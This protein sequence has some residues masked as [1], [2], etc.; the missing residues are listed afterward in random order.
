MVI[1]ILAIFSKNFQNLEMH[2]RLGSLVIIFWFSPKND[3][4]GS[5]MKVLK[6]FGIQ[7]NYNASP[8]KDPDIQTPLVV[9]FSLEVVFHFRH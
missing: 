2:P 1:P 3:N 6:F 4:L 9:S 5:K 7:P 8:L